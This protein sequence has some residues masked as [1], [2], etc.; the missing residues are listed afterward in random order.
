MYF[1]EV[2]ILSCGK[3]KK[4]TSQMVATAEMSKLSEMPP[5]PFEAFDYVS[6]LL[7]IL[8]TLSAIMLNKPNSSQF[9]AND[10]V[11]FAIADFLIW[12]LKSDWCC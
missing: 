9:V 11:V 2:Q 3:R 5:G 7:I 10:C 8:W 12:T 1:C 4:V 6:F